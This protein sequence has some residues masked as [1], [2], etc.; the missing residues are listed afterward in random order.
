FLRCGIGEAPIV[1]QPDVLDADFENLPG[2]GAAYGNGTRA[3]VARQLRLLG[4]M[5]PV[6]GHETPLL[7]S[8]MQDVSHSL[9]PRTTGHPLMIRIRRVAQ[10]V[11][12]EV[13]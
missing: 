8:S 12:H 9:E 5:N 7:S 11:A 4:R 3:D 2:P 13:E 10:A 6:L 1:V